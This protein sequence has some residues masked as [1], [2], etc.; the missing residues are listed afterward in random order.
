[1][2]TKLIHLCDTIKPVL[3]GKFIVLDDYIRKERSKY[4]N[5]SFQIKE[6]G[7]EAQIKSRKKR[8]NKDLD[9]HQ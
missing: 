6:L 3:L 1:M 4:N 5:L 9:S 7:H 8:N 2:K